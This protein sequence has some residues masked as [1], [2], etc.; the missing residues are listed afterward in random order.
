VAEQDVVVGLLERVIAGLAAVEARLG[1]RLD[2]V[3][4][5]LDKIEGRLDKIE[6][7]LDKIEGRLDKI[8][9]D[10]ARLQAGQAR[11][12]N[13]QANMRRDLGLQIERMLNRQ[14]E[15]ADDMTVVMARLTRVDTSTRAAV[16]EVR[17]MHSLN[18]RL[19]QRV[20]ALEQKDQP[21]AA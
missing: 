5:R 1:A 12:E 11:I 7:R 17:A 4:G 2:A 13:E 20:T 19:T 8:E 3:E 15:L 9:A 14:N 6:G 16:D 18:T 21:P 10:V